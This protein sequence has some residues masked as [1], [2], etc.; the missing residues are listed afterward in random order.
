MV[1][2]IPLV[3]IDGSWMNP[4]EGERASLLGFQGAEARAHRWN[5]NKWGRNKLPDND[6]GY[7]SFFI[8]Q[9]NPKNHCKSNV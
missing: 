3:I 7:L 4:C 2:G 8:H 5:W 6:R 9:N 1:R